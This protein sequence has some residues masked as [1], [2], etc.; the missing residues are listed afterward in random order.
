MP[1]LGKHSLRII[2]LL[3]DHSGFTTELVRMKR[4]SMLVDYL[5]IAIAVE[6]NLQYVK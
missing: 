2:S 1:L 6:T 4:Y 5:S 3:D